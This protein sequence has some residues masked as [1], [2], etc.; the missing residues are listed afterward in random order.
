M[1][2]PVNKKVVSWFELK[3][4]FSNLNT[5]I[6]HK[7][8]VQ[9]EAIPLVFLPGIMGSCLRVAGTNGEGN[10][11][12]GLPNLRWNPSSSYWMWSNYSGISGAERRRMVIGPDGEGFN[13]NLLEVHNSNPVGNGFQGVGESSYH[14]FLA[15][16]QN[17]EHWGPLCK[18]F[19]FPVYAIG[20]NWTDT[21]LNNGKKVAKRI[22]EIIDEAKKVTGSCEKVIIITHSM[23]GLVGRSASELAGAKS[24]ILGIVHGVQPVTGSCGAF[25]RVKAGF[26]G[27]GPTSRVLGNS[28]KN[29]TPILG[30]M[31]GGLELLPNH[32]YKDNSGNKQWLSVKEDSSVTL[33]LPLS[34]PYKEIY[35]VKSTGNEVNNSDGKVWALIDPDLLDPGRVIALTSDDDDPDSLDA[36]AA[37]KPWEQY[38]NELAKAEK[39]QRM[40]SNKQHDTTFSFHGIGHTSADKIEYVSESVWVEKE[41]YEKRGFRGR[42]VLKKD[43]KSHD[44]RAILQE[45]SGD[46]DGTVPSSSGAAL[47]TKSQKKPAPM[48]GD[49]EHEP[50]FNNAQARDFVVQSILVMCQKKLEQKVK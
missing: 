17:G 27:M 29:V 37:V 1:K 20:Y 8:E 28:G 13:Q 15:F 10:S 3:Q 26:E 24:K 42:Y 21:N 7:F 25:W 23:G 35:R 45:P 49:M 11:E 18:L 36:Q 12:N 40:V 14:D 2:D 31:P 39:F 9:R 4:T 19:D 47:D 5:N 34:D 38:L 46:G 43:G 22:D 50:A 44:R 32:I 16:L 30:N 41:P 33:S 48:G 6:K